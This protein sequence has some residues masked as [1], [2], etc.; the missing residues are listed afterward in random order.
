MIDSEVMHRTTWK[1]RPDAGPD[2]GTQSQDA[3]H[4]GQSLLVQ[5][6]RAAELST[7]VAIRGVGCGSPSSQ[8]VAEGVSSSDRWALAG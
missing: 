2:G 6:T 8:V 5:A 1:P 3:I 4:P 7:P